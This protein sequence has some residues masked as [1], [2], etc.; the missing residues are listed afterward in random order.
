MSEQSSFEERHDRA[1]EVFSRFAPDV[2][3][4]RVARSMERRLGALGTLRLQH[5]GR[6]P[7]VRVPQLSRR[8]RSAGRH[9][10][11]RPPPPATRSSRR[12]SAWA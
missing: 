6:R 5:R 12:T 2:E 11:A 10:G 1:T 8:D 7:V 3:P 9:L 4:E